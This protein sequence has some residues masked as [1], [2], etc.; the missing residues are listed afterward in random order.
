MQKLIV[1]SDTHITSSNPESLSLFP[2]YMSVHPNEYIKT[3]KCLDDCNTSLN[4]WLEQNK[5]VDM[6]IHLGD[7]T[8]GWSEQGIHHQEVLRLAVDAV[9]SYKKVAH[10]VKICWGNHDT[11]YGNTVDGICFESLKRCNDIS[12]LYWSHFSENILFIGICSSLIKY[13][14]HNEKILN[15]KQKQIQFIKDILNKNKEHFW[16]LCSHEYFF[17]KDLIEIINQHKDVFQRHLYGDKHMIMAGHLLKITAYV[18]FQSIFQIH[19][20]S[21]LCPSVAPLW[22]R[23]GM[24]LEGELK[25]EKISLT[26]KS[27]NNISWADSFPFWRALWA[28]FY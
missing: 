17:D 2:G 12:P 21:I 9:C 20:K 22:C 13:K 5:P 8:S 3:V 6:L 15:L 18:S 25:G 10:V 19:R 28:M 23:G 26:R 16:I 24:L 7:L 4:Y 11:G 27:F 1:I 14:G